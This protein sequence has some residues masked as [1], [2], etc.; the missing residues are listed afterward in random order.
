MEITE[1]NTELLKPWDHIMAPATI[2][3]QQD[4]YERQL[5]KGGVDAQP[6]LRLA[7]TLFA[8]KALGKNDALIHEWNARVA[9]DKTF[10]NFCQFVQHKLTKRM[11]HDKVTSMSVG[12][13]IANQAKI[14]EEQDDASV[15]ANQAAWAL[16]EVASVMQA[17]L[18]KQIKKLIE[19]FT[20]S[21]E[22]MNK[23]I[24]SPNPNLCGNRAHGQH[25]ACKHCGLKHHDPDSFWE[26]KSNKDKH[27]ANWKPMADH[28]LKSSS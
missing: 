23:N 26:L 25:S 8:F 17:A 14:K 20:K 12:C 18:E 13:G 7:I 15:K 3:A 21:F 24:P 11:K 27:P 1:L 6:A 9:I 28:K 10:E 22:A 5:E 2:F 19:M 16:A 4:K